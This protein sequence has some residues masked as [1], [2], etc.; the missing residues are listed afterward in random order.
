MSYINRNTY[1]SSILNNEEYFENKTDVE[2]L[3]L[4]S[5]HE[6][7]LY[8][9]AR[10]ILRDNQDINDAI[11][12]CIL[13]AYEKFHTIKSIDKFKPWITKILINECYKI[14]KHNKKYDY[15]NELKDS[16]LSYT[17]DYSI[18]I[19]S[20]INNLKIKHKSIIILYYYEDLD[21]ETISYILKVPKGTVKSR[22]SR[23]RNKLKMI[24]D[25]NEEE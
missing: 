20:A 7:I 9:V 10:Y 11:S 24:L 21:I 8:N 5:L 16:E 25:I 19:I 18:E 12:E 13:K 14:I 22:L 15:N 1:R 17:D 4:L 3:N 23:A 2:F 6:K